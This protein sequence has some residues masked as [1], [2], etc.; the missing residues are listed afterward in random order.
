MQGYTQLTR[1]QRYQIYAYLKAG[2]DQ[3][4][5]ADELAVHK[6]TISRKLARNQGRRGY[7]PKQAQACC[8]R[9]RSQSC[10]PRIGV[11]ANWYLPCV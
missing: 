4:Q 7:R 6:S 9:R 3:T 2:L 11:R 5:T 1:E 8:E 10:G